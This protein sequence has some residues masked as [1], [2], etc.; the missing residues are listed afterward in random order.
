MIAQRFGD[1]AGEA[2]AIDGQRTTSRNGMPIGTLNDK[3]SSMRISS[4]MTPT[5]LVNASERR[6]LVQTSSANLSVW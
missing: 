1:R 6:E 2:V 5:A 4:L 3:E